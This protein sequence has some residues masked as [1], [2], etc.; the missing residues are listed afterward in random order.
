VA[1]RF[2][3]Y[4]RGVELANGFEEL[5]DASEQRSRFL[6]DRRERARRGLPLPEMDQSLLDA[7]A[8]GLPPVSGVALGFDRLLMLRLGVGEIGDV[9]AFT[10]ERA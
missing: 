7:L 4:Y 5:A 1:L 6:L 10:L 9:L 8:A 3:L 2:E